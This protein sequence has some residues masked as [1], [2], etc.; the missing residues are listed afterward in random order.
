MKKNILC[1]QK[2]KLACFI[3]TLF[4]VS[5][6]SYPSTVMAHGDEIDIKAQGNTDL[7][8]LTDIQIQAF[9]LK[10]SPVVKRAIAEQ[11]H[12]N[13]TI[14]LMPDAQADVTVRISGQVTEIAALL[15]Q[16]V[17]KGQV[18]ATVQ[19]RLVGNPP[20]SVM[21][22]APIAGIV[23]A[24][25]INLGQAIE[26]NTVLF[27]ISNRKQVIALA[28]VYEEDLGKIRL[29][30]EALIQVLSYPN[31][32]FSGKVTLIEPLIDALTR[33]V[34]VWVTI[35]NTDNLLYPNM[36]AKVSILL[37][38]NDHALVVPTDAIIAANDETFV[39]I[40]QG[41]QF[42]RKIITIGNTEGNFTEVMQGLLINDT[43]VIQGNRELY[44]VWLTGDQAQPKSGEE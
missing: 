25:N 30:Q 12:L 42:L 28:S 2:V 13:G 10:T 21:V 24:R 19:S 18:L 23:D 15:G 37:Q 33:T 29:D 1:I 16:S 41:N 35:D 44:T 9:D 39:F 22:T 8:T 34:K 7:I 27:H 3:F 11:L 43:V 17:A 40:K 38:K 20:P 32:T 26:P 6:A 4:M 14:T 36:F 5:M 31:K